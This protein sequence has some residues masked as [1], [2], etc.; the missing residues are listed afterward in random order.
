[1]TSIK[2]NVAVLATLQA[3]LF[4]NNS[5]A[6]ALNGLVGYA[7]AA[8]KSLATVPVTGWVIGAAA[9][10]YFASL[11]MRRIGRRAG[12]TFGTLVGIVGASICC[13]AIYNANF[14]LFCFGTTIFG[15]YNAF[16]QYYRFAAAD[17]APAD[18]KSRAISLVLAG[19][20]VGGII[21]PTTSQWT[22]DIFPV[23]YLGAYLALVAFLFVVLVVLRFLDIP[24]PST[25]EHKEPARP[26][27][28]VMAQP[29]F[30]VAVLAAAI[31]YGVMNLLMTATPLAMDICGHP[32]SAAA[33]V[34]SWHVIAMF[35]PSFFTGSLIKRFGVLNIIVVGALINVACIGVALSGIAV[36]Y[37][38]VSLILLGLS[39][40]FLY[41]GGTTLLTEAYAPSE[42]AKAQGVND[43]LVFLTM[44]ASSFSS[45]LLL[46]TQGWALLN[47][48]ALPFV[49]LV[50]IAAI[51]LG[52]RRREVALA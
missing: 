10:T 52:A 24:P 44:A 25:E 20:L 45:G 1:M 4:T 11:L 46:E 42:R 19:G 6:I 8:N 5:T 34:I 3:L 15:V 14:W 47:W 39:W 27:S 29:V 26:M 30:I 31:G 9:S 33:G 41:I 48:L 28:R 43:L 50:G 18:Y 23:A 7:L 37:F 13:L 38:Y 49:L 40:N 32:Y 35:A 16:G 51:W 17:A 22:K 21:G 36:A 2:K 12:F